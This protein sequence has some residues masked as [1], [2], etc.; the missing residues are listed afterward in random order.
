M[1]AFF[2]LMII[3]WILLFLCKL[4]AEREVLIFNFDCV[5]V[6]LAVAH[7]HLYAKM[8]QTPMTTIF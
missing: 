5:A 1:I 2:M 4:T 3:R 7:C 8:T 6:T